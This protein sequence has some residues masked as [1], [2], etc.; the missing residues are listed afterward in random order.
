[1]NEI[2][3]ESYWTHLYWLTVLEEQKSYTR[4]AEKLAVSKSADSAVEAN[5]APPVSENA[6]LLQAGGDWLQGLGEQAQ[7][8]L[9]QGQSDIWDQLTQQFEAQLLRTTLA[10]THG[11]RVEAASRLGIGR[12]T[13]TR[14][15]QELGLDNVEFD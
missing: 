6:A 1:M 7:A 14:K 13:I 2:R 5:S 11:R 4:A 10:A 3:P 9:A 12:N 8:L 15:L